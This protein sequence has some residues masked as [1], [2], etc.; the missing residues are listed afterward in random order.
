MITNNNRW[1]TALASVAV[2]VLWTLICFNTNLFTEGGKFLTGEYI[3]CYAM[4]LG[5]WAICALKFNFSKIYTLA[6]S[7][8]VFLIMPFACTQSP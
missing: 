7:V 5:M 1:K 3:L 8:F 4:T 2:L 6:A